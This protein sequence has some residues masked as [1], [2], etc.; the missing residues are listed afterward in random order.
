MTERKVKRKAG[1]PKANARTVTEKRPARIPVAGQ[2]NILGVE[3]KDKNYVYRF[4]RDQGARVQIFLRGYWDYVNKD[5]VIVD[6]S[7][8]VSLG[9]TVT[10]I[11]DPK[12]N[13]K[14]VLMRIKK[15]YYDEDQFAKQEAINVTEQ[16]MRDQTEGETNYGSIKIG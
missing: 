15:E 7:R 1:R 11:G 13:E 3:G 2:S 16:G 9:S 10:I 14:L 8:E 5:D 4:I 6:S 12:T